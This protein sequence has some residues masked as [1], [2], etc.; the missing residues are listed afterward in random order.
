[1]DSISFGRCGAGVYATIESDDLLTYLQSLKDSDVLKLH[2]KLEQYIKSDF[3][4]FEN[5][6][7]ESKNIGKLFV[8]CIKDSFLVGGWNGLHVAVSDDNLRFKKQ[9]IDTFLTS[10][11]ELLFAPNK[12]G[13]TPLMLASRANANITTYIIETYILTSEDRNHAKFLSDKGESVLTSSFDLKERR[14]VA[15][16][17]EDI[18]IYLIKNVYDS[19]IDISTFKKAICCKSCPNEVIVDMSAYLAGSINL[20]QLSDIV[21]KLLI[22][23]GLDVSQFSRI[24]SRVESVSCHSF[25]CHEEMYTE[26]FNILKELAKTVKKGDSQTTGLL[27]SS[28]LINFLKYSTSCVSPVDQKNIAHFTCQEDNVFLLEILARKFQA[29]FSKMM[30]QY[31]SDNKRPAYYIRKPIQILEKLCRSI[32]QPEI[33]TQLCRDNRYN[34]VHQ[35]LKRSVSVKDLDLFFGIDSTLLLSLL[36]DCNRFVTH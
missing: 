36:Q 29:E 7:C 4:M 11:P 35:I 5:C 15:D 24:L 9:L 10:F 2:Q 28:F 20:K 6:S 30:L 27:F 14:Q 34:I 3:H 31:D 16:N 19:N 21:G 22:K 13:Q 25:T 1:M 17:T 26:N 33:W 8:Q 12:K 32:D 18:S 23:E